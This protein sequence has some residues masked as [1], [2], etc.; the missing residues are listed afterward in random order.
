MRSLSIFHNNLW[1]TRKADSYTSC[2]TNSKGNDHYRGSSGPTSGA[3]AAGATGPR[4]Y[5]ARLTLTVR[6]TSAARDHSIQCPNASVL[7][8]C[9]D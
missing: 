3:E 2:Y 1:F 6:H 8:D 7:R 4:P 9:A 5:A